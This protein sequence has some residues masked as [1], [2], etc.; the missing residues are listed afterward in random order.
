MKEAAIEQARALYAEVPDR[1]E[2]M[3]FLDTMKLTPDLMRLLEEP[4]IKMADKSRVI[5]RL[6]KEA[7]FSEKMRNFLM[8]LT[9]NHQIDLLDE[10]ME[11]YA[12]IWDYENHYLKIEAIFAREPSDEELKEAR[13]YLG[14]RYRS[15]HVQLCV[16]VDPSIIGGRILRTRGREY[17][18]SYRGR[19]QQLEKSLIEEAY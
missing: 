14:R 11:A 10:I 2:V 7:G 15:G 17:D 8:E 9:R 16:E 19:L 1:Q 12:K 13:E 5:L 3:E 4:V 6:S 18:Q